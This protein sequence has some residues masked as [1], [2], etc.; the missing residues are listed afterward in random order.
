MALDKFH[1]VREVADALGYHPDTLKLKIRNGEF[2]AV[3]FGR[4]WRISDSALRDVQVVTP[5]GLRPLSEYMS[6]KDGK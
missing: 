3:K 4:E 6:A 2:P 1:T 5:H